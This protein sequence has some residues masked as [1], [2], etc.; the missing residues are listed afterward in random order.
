MGYQV[1]LGDNVTL[2]PNFQWVFN[3]SG[4]GS[5]LDALVLGMQMS[6]FF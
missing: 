6:F 4:T 3:P 5:V 2:Q 1:A